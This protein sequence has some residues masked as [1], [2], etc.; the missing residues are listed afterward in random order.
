MKLIF[1]GPPGAGKG[2]HAENLSKQYQV[3]HLA[4]GDILRRHIREKTP[5]GIQAKDTIERGELVPD[6]LVN[7]MMF[8]EI[9]QVKGGK[10]FILDG[11]PRT[12]G[13]A[14]ALSEFLESGKMK[15]DAVVNFVASES[16][17]IDRLSGR[18]VCPQCNR[19][20]HIHNIPPKKEGLCD[21]C[22]VALIQ[23]KDDQPETIRHRLEVYHKET[24]ALV[25]YY[26][27]KKWLH[28]VNAD[29]EVGEVLA[30]LKLLFERLKISL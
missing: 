1:L 11:F 3:S 12:I 4:T 8:A 7:Q 5:L 28:D 6:T 16:V 30:A 2:T 19:N 29:R 25:D 13:Q 17:I 24:A 27:K 20:Y 23:R 9:Q 15:I 22:G 18:R 21:R 10:G 26:K 14:D